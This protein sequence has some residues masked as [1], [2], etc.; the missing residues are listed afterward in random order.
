[1][2]VGGVKSLRYRYFSL[3]QYNIVINSDWE[4]EVEDALLMSES[5]NKMLTLALNKVL[6]IGW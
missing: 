4:Q 3:L 1:M 2:V 6:G 5:R